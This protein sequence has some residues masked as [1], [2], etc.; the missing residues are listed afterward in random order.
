[1]A[2]V[3]N[4]NR[5]SHQAVI[6]GELTIYTVKA[7]KERLLADLSEHQ[8]LELD[9]SEVNEID[10]AGLQLLVMIK[11]QAKA[12]GKGLQ[13]TGHSP[14]VVELMA[15]SVLDG[16]FGDPLLMVRK[17]SAKGKPL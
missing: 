17:S 12:L 13:M 7:L 16:F 4:K 3:R 2:S 11:Q 6:E 1:M 8:E 5:L 15:L 14:V 10:A 9:L